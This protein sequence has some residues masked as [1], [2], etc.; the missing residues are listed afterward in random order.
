MRVVHQAGRRPGKRRLSSTINGVIAAHSQQLGKFSTADGNRSKRA[1]TEMANRYLC[2]TM[3]A[4]IAV[5]AANATANPL[6][7]HLVLLEIIEPQ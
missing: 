4:A 3:N 6:G 5:H 2:A 1:P 7:H